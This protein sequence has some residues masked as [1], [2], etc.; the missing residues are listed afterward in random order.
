[1]A[2]NQLDPTQFEEVAD[3][4][5]ATLEPAPAMKP[6]SGEFEVMPEYA[7][8]VSP[9]TPI[10]KSPVDM[11]DRLRFALGNKAGVVK[12]LKSKFENV[13]QDKHG[14]MVV[15]KQGIWYRVDPKDLGDGDAWDRTKE[16]ISDAADIAP[17]VA[18]NAA[19]GAV[20]GAAAG[21][22]GIA[23]G[24]SIGAGATVASDMYADEI[25]ELISDN[26]KKAA[27]LGIGLTG[28]G[29]V[30]GGLA[31]AKASLPAI[32]TAGVGE[33]ARTSMGRLVGTYEGDTTDQI[34]DSGWEM[35]ANLGGSYMAAGVKPTASMISGAITKTG[36]AFS[37][38]PEAA[39]EF[40]KKVHGP[41]TG[42]GPDNIENMA[43][44]HV[45]INPLVKSAL[46]GGGNVEGAIG[47]LT[48]SQVEDTKQMIS[49]IQPALSKQYVAMSKDAVEKVP[50][51]FAGGPREIV[52]GTWQRA[53]DLGLGKVQLNPKGK[54][55]GFQLSSDE[56]LV[57]NA[58]RLAQ[59]G[60]TDEAQMV[61]ELVGNDDARKVISKFFNTINPHR[62]TPD[63]QGS[64]AART[65]VGFKKAING[66]V[67]DLEA[68][69]TEKGMNQATRVIRLL[70]SH[71]DAR[72]ETK[73]EPTDGSKNLFRAFND[74]YSQ[75][76]T[77]VQPLLNIQK[78]A[79]GKAGDQAYLTYLN[80]VTNNTRTGALKQDTFHKLV[81][82]TNPE[83]GETVFGNQVKSAYQSILNKE[84]AK[85]FMPKIRTGISFKAGN[86]GAGIGIATKMMGATVPAAGLAAVGV[87]GTALAASSPRL[88]GNLITKEA[89]GAQWL[90]GK[91]DYVR[92]LI[93]QGI[94]QTGDTG[95]AKI[96]SDVYMRGLNMTQQL[97]KSNM[98]HVLLKDPNALNTFAQTLRNGFHGV[99]QT[100]DQLMS[101]VPQE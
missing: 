35:L 98:S 53:A 82:M 24:A 68:E 71:I 92:S 73:F 63:Q 3:G 56:Q 97:A 95:A 47:K 25:N 51:G 44:N 81:T 96:M 40:A 50:A 14:N 13:T 4:H 10:N 2:L 8:G 85:A 46:A 45:D 62:I 28:V 30:K 54:P 79:Q 31:V 65:L 78:Q 22:V 41:I 18:K 9:D 60:R 6:M 67:T 69:A 74:A 91:T 52:E 88:A 15:Q 5:S 87:G 17:Q 23:V 86:T 100:R 72:I 29:V 49:G 90:Q 83:T 38:A 42:I 37:N 66:R 19:M 33:A 77:Q 34:M 20:A 16:L 75:L 39:I 7:S 84:T 36:Q 99:Y 70:D 32:L 80:S 43:R 64:N 76:K 58:T 55:F 94:Q 26:P 27:A 12:E 101:Q 57:A 59:A 11:V 48:V 93:N 61:Q 1:M 21:P 89:V